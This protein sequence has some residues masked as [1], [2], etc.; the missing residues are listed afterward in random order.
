VN[1]KGRLRRLTVAK[2]SRVKTN[3]DDA[4]QPRYGVE[5]FTVGN[6]AIV[7]LVQDKPSAVSKARRRTGLRDESGYE[8][9]GGLDAQIAQIRELVELPLTRPELYAHFGLSPS[10]SWLPPLNL[11]SHLITL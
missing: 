10:T 11:R 7:S 1:Y 9:I 8:A 6:N 2:I 4:E 5:F 3:K